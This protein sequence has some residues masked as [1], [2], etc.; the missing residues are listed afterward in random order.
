[1]LKIKEEVDHIP[2]DQLPD[3]PE[4]PEMSQESIDRF[5]E[6][7]KKFG[8]DPAW[9]MEEVTSCLTELKDKVDQRKIKNNELKSHGVYETFEEL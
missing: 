5:R 8:G 1:M 3:V 2:F 9:D 6:N 4:I 7:M